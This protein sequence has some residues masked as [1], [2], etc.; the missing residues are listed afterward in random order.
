MKIYDD[1]KINLGLKMPSQKICNIIKASNSMC[2]QDELVALYSLIKDYHT[3]GNIYEIGV[4]AGGSARILGLSNKQIHVFDD[5]K[6]NGSRISKTTA[7]NLLGPMTNI[8]IHE[9]NIRTKEYK[10]FVNSNGQ[11]GILHLD[12][13]KGPGA[14]KKALGPLL[15]KVIP[16]KTIWILQ[17]FAVFVIFALPIMLSLMK[18]FGRVV[19]G[20]PFGT[21]YFQFDSVPDASI[22]EYHSMSYENRCDRIITVYES[23]KKD[24][25]DLFDGH[26]EIASLA[27]RASMANAHN[28]IDEVMEY[29]LQIKLLKN[30]YNSPYIDR[31]FN[32]F[33]KRKLN[34]IIT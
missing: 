11:V 1:L 32:Y 34:V 14:L 23:M 25:P 24:Y 8:E 21:I 5:W 6:E 22:F 16:G 4:D 33:V 26:P 28:M 20:I 2:N 9:V 29:I 18:K 19:G 17:D 3:I 7:Y 31:V 15:D 12:A 30:T 13:P 27:A 10:D